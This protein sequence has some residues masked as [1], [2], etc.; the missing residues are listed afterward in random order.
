M[1]S[2]TSSSPTLQALWRLRAMAL[3][4]IGPAAGIV[5]VQC[6]F[7]LP[8]ALWWSAGGMSLFMFTIFF[9]LFLKE[10][11]LLVNQTKTSFPIKK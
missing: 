3:F 2:L 4:L 6:I 1:A 10:R 7:G 9:T 11:T 8:V 5:L